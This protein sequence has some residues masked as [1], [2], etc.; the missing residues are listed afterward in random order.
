MHDPEEFSLSKIPYSSKSR[1]MLE[2]QKTQVMFPKYADKIIPIKK[3]VTDMQGGSDGEALRLKLRNTD[4]WRG[5]SFA[6]THPEM[7]RLI[8]YE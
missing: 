4:L 5:I 6:N 7:A 3:I 2:L 8:R 1:V